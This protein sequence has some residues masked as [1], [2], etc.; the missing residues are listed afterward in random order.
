MHH[1]HYSDYPK[2]SKDE[3]QSTRQE[4]SHFSS[5]TLQTSS[6]KSDRILIRKFANW[7]KP[8]ITNEYLN[9]ILLLALSLPSHQRQQVRRKK[10]VGENK[11][12]TS[13]HQQISVPKVHQKGRI[14]R[15][16]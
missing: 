8:P 12:K 16:E 3:V 5:F 10:P 1:H 2:S 14:R 4:Y 6:Q 7:H 15:E 9:L 13:G 11:F